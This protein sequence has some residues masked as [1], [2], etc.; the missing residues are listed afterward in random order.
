MDEIRA[1][2]SVVR[3]RFRIDRIIL[4]GSVA[5]GTLHEG[6]DIDLIVVGD[7]SGRFH[8]RIAAL[9]DLTDL[10]VEPLCYTP[11]EFRHLLDE[12]NTFILSALSEGIDL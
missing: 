12:Q 11:E 1:F 6:S 7:F 5:S 10:P 3:A 2:A 4:F 8:Q 9:L